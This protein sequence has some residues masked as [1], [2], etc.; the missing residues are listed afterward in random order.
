MKIT[1]TKKH[2]VFVQEP[3]GWKDVDHL[4][5][6]GKT[7]KKKFEEKNFGKAIHVLGM[8][9]MVNMEKKAFCDW[10]SETTGARESYCI[11]C[12]NALFDWS[13]EFLM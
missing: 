10:M 11:N 9:L 4:P 3:I 1:S 8:F 12:F 6:V 13:N 7:L 5:G 2:R